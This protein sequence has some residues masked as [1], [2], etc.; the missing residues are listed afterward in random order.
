MN[1]L[2]FQALLHMLD[3]IPQPGTAVPRTVQVDVGTPK[4]VENPQR[5]EEPAFKVDVGEAKFVEKPKRKSA[6]QKATFT[7]DPIEVD[8]RPPPPRVINGQT[9]D[10][11]TDV[12]RP[13]A[14]KMDK[15]LLYTQ[16]YRSKPELQDHPGSVK[17]DYETGETIPVTIDYTK[18]PDPWVRQYGYRE[19]RKKE[20]ER[21]EK[22]KARKARATLPDELLVPEII[23][24]KRDQ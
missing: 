23:R 13:G 1:D 7:L 21:Q 24:V 18:H 10:D 15:Q 5:T 12:W 14:Y 11:V 3:T 20:R 16:A 9:G 22:I 4:F 8:L 19:R 17:F 6:K 2:D